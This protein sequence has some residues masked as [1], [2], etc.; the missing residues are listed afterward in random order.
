MVFGWLANFVLRGGILRFDAAV[1]NTVHSW[2]SPSFTWS[3]RV[4]TELGEV[5]FLVALG[6]F[7]VWRLAVSGRRHAALIFVWAVAGAEAL[8]QILKFLFHRPRPGAFFGLDQPAT[9]SFPSGHALV[10][11][12]FYGVLAAV[13]TVREPSRARRIAIWTFAAL[14]AGVIGFTRVYLGVHYPSDILAGYAAAVIWVAAVSAGYRMWLRR[15]RLWGGPDGPRRTPP[16][17]CL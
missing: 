1:R 9:Y 12:V 4:V 7:L 14:L 3:M 13:L 10:S 16:S 2:A 17:G 11:T 15:R 8:D 5:Y 6:A